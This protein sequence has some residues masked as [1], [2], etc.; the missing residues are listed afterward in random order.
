MRNLFLSLILVLAGNTA[1]FAQS[2]SP[3]DIPASVLVDVSASA[4]NASPLTTLVVNATTNDVAVTLPD[5]TQV[6]AGKGLK[7]LLEVT[8]SSHYANF[9]TLNSQ[10]IN[11]AAASGYAHLA[12][13]GSSVSFVSD[14]ANWLASTGSL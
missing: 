6:P 2:L 9:L 10:T 8:A 1:V 7:V 14:G 5:A 3:S 12:N 11:G 13:V 4:V